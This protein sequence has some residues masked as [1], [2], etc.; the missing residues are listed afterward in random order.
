MM[1]ILSKNM[2][3]NSGKVFKKGK[4]V[5]EMYQAPLNK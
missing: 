1:A 5:N 2:L 4:P 3:E